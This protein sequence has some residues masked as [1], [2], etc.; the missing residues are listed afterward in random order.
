MLES[1]LIAQA[2]VFFPAEPG[3]I[4]GAPTMVQSVRG[5]YFP[6][7]S[8]GQRLVA[9][10]KSVETRFHA[11]IHLTPDADRDLS[12]D[13]RFQMVE[14]HWLVRKAERWVGVEQ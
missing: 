2:T 1:N 7:D 13:A 5:T 6:T 14:R 9:E 3:S 8:A 4:N 11:S 10:G 12:H